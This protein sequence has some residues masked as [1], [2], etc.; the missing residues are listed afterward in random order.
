M[1]QSTQRFM[2]PAGLSSPSSVQEIT[3]LFDRRLRQGKFS[4]YRPI[5]TGFPDLDT[6]LGGGLH[7]EDLILVGGGQGTG[8]LAPA[9]TSAAYYGEKVRFSP[10]R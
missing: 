1:T 10:E 6:V 7:A 9:V 2:L 5:P 3:E 8:T 4:N